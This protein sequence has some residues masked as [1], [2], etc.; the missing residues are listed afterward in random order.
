MKVKV[1]VMLVVCAL[2]VG[3]CGNK[4][5]EIKKTAKR[6]V[7]KPVVVAKD[8]MPPVPEPKPEPVVVQKPDNKYFLIRASFEKE[9]NAMAYKDELT[10]EGFD[11][12]V[13][14]RKWGENADFYKVSYKGFADRETAFKELAH[15]K[16]QPGYE[17]VWLLIKR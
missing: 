2:L 14:V 17:N 10:K 9:S 3:A 1:L 11:S 5:E 12:E 13:I 4:K 15:E 7:V 8:T 6:E 16:K